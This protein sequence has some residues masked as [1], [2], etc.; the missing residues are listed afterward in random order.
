M[1]DLLCFSN[2]CLSGKKEGV[3]LG[4][5]SA[6]ALLELHEYSCCSPNCSAALLGA[7]W[8]REIC[9]CQSTGAW[10]LSGRGRKVV[11]CPWKLMILFQWAELHIF[12]MVEHSLAQCHSYKRHSNEKKSMLSEVCKV[13]SG[14]YRLLQ[15]S[16][17]WYP[18][19]QNHV[20]I[21][22]MA[23]DRCWMLMCQ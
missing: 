20:F 17:W 14:D 18:G 4:E 11:G 6:L 19:L 9:C 2:R 7:P 16:G 12:Q 22:S 23:T 3:E 5:E 15:F 21:W 13:L 1:K 10:W 8:S